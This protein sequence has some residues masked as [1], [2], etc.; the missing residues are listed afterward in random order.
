MRNQTMGD[1]PTTV[2]S[3]ESIIAERHQFSFGVSLIKESTENSFDSATP[4]P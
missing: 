1:A 4:S 2:P 3:W